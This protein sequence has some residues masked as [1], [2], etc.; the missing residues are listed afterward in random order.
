[1]NADIY[2]SSN[3]SII[4]PT[5]TMITRYTDNSF[6]VIQSIYESDY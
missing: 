3:S 4:N 2:N 5:S 1:M 6:K